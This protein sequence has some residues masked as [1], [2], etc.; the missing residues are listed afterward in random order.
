MIIGHSD[1]TTNKTPKQNNGHMENVVCH[2]SKIYLVL[3]RNFVGFC[4]FFLLNVKLSLA[5]FK[6]TKSVNE[7]QGVSL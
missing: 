1:A 7:N 2:K 4:F 3:F 6:T 5:V